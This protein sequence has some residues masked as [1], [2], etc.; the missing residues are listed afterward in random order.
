MQRLAELRPRWET[1]GLPP[2]ALQ[3]RL[4]GISGLLPTELTRAQAGADGYVRRIWD[5]W[6]RER[7]EYSDCLLPKT[8]WRF[9]ALRPANHPQRRLALAAQWS[10]ADDLP[11]RLEN[12]C[13]R[14]VPDPALSHSLL[15]TLRVEGDDFWS[16]HYTF[17]SARLKKAQ[18]LLGS[19]RVTDLA[20][21]VVLPWLWARAAEGKSTGVQRSIE[22]R[23][24][25]WP[26][27]EDNSLLRHARQ[28]LL[29]GPPARALPGA[30]AQQGL[31][32]MVR[33]F[34]DHSNSICESCK[35]PL[36]VKDWRGLRM[37]LPEDQPRLAPG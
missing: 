25:A 23:Y 20:V 34:C 37:K 16:W 11:A 13:A 10:A 9:N 12:W 36:L 15:E 24:F 27:A 17:R 29:G 6:W 19:T 26:A 4:F 7:D 3:A 32:Q 35:L 2:L 5:I 14:E 8:L 28:R 18:P 21:N 30:A 33:D 22:H 1:P 31:I